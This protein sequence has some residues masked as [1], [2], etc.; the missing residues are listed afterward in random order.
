MRRRTA[1]FLQGVSDVPLASIPGNRQAN[2]SSPQQSKTGERRKREEN[3]E[4]PDIQGSGIVQLPY[5]RLPMRLLV[6]KVKS[7]VMAR[8]PSLPNDHLLRLERA[9]LGINIQNSDAMPTGSTPSCAL[10]VHRPPALVHPLQVVPSISLLRFK[11]YS[12]SIRRGSSGLLLY[13]RTRIPSQH[14][15]PLT[16]P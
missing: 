10:M 6:I 8:V 12:P 4:R 3:G 11:R 9:T 7:F 13:I 5:Q 14:Q 2:S 1:D 15:R 16:A